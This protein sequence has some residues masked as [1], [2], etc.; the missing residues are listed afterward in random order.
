MPTAQHA[1]PTA[2][3]APAAKTVLDAARAAMAANALIALLF[4]K[5]SL[6]R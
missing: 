5:T 3:H 2:Q 1:A 4:I 6:S